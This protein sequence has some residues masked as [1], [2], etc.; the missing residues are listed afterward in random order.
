ML[1][2]RYLFPQH[3]VQVG[4]IKAELVRR[5]QRAPLLHMLAQNIAQRVLQQVGGG[6]VA[7]DVQTPGFIHLSLYLITHCQAAIADLPLVDDDIGRDSD[8]ISNGELPG[9][10]VNLAGIAHLAAHLTVERRRFQDQAGALAL[11]HGVHG[12]AINQQIYNHR[13]AL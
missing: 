10:T 11:C 9:G 6:M 13:P 2:R 3:G 5:H 8:G 1:H 12:T 7:G 4:E